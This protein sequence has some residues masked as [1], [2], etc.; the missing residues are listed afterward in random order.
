MFPVVSVVGAAQLHVRHPY[1]GG[2]ACESRVELAA[3][4]A[5]L[6][7]MRRSS[8]FELNG[9]SLVCLPETKRKAR[10]KKRAS[11]KLNLPNSALTSR[12]TI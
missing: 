2:R 6:P 7:L 5:C 9:G 1:Y 3:S 11:H 4:D 10:Y 8:D 12:A